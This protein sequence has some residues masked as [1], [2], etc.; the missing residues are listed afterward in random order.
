MELYESSGGLAGTTMRGL[1]CVLLTSVGAT[2]G[3][4]RKTPLMRVEHQGQYLVVAS[5]GGAPTN[6]QWYSNLLAHPQVQL[7]D[8]P[9]KHDMVAREL[10]GPEREV[11]WQRAVAAFPD[12]AQY[13]LKTERV[14]PILLLTAQG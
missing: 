12:Y 8:G 7:Q 9:V 14:I 5:Q 4:L 3:L 1:P 13:Q 10:F 2:S 11:W 6:P